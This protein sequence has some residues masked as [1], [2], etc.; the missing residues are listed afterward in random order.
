MEFSD[1]SIS[2]SEQNE[3]TYIIGYTFLYFIAHIENIVPPVLFIDKF[4]VVLSFQNLKNVDILYDILF[5]K[6]VCLFQKS[7]I[8]PFYDHISPFLEC[9]PLCSLL[10]SPSPL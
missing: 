5:T 3:Y 6:Q 7:L 9:F 4:N 8:P 10:E 2:Y 1:S